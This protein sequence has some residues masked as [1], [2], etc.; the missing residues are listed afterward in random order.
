MDD[1][2]NFEIYLPSSSKAMADRSEIGEDGS[3]KSW[4]SR[5]RKKPFYMSEKT[6]LH[7]IKNIFHNYLKGYHLVKNRGVS[8]NFI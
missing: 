8:F 3:K 1:V 5:E 2:I 4:I 6:F 7:E